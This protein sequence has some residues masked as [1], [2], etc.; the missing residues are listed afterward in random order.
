M[1]PEYPCAHCTIGGAARAVMEA[2][3]GDAMQ[4][5]VSTEAMPDT[6]RKYPS[7]AAF[8]E[9]EAYSRILGGIHFR[10]SL[11]TRAAIGH[12]IGEQTVAKTMRPQ[13]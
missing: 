6:I 1:H 7:F 11:I 10:N 12:K 9:E 8:A 2:E 13:S 5:A 4:F 3:F